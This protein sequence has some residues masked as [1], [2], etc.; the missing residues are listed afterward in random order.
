LIRAKV[1]GSLLARCL[2]GDG[3][4]GTVIASVRGAVYIQVRGL[5]VVSLSSDSNG[6]S[7][8]SATLDTDPE[9]LDWRQGTPLFLSRAGV[10]HEDLRVVSFDGASVWDAG[11]VVGPPAASRQRIVAAGKAA[12]DLVWP[13][14]AV[15]GAG[16]VLEVLS[17]YRPGASEWALN[18]LGLG[19]GLTPA[20]DDALAGITAVLAVSSRSMRALRFRYHVVASSYRRTNLISVSLLAQCASGM[21]PE[22]LARFIRALLLAEDVAQAAERLSCV[23]HAS[24]SFMALGAILGAG[25]SQQWTEAYP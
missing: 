12:M 22:V 1:I 5:P 6:N 10:F 7:A 23:G 14:C 13:G 20:G 3:L 9:T 18:L 8:L 4:S 15:P 21:P 25:T 11:G 24:G 2:T 17:R 16:E 19:P